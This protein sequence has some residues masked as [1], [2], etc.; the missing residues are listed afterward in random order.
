MADLYIS[1]LSDIDRANIDDALID[2]AENHHNA[3]EVSDNSTAWTLYLHYTDIRNAMILNGVLSDIE[4][5]DVMDCLNASAELCE[6]LRGGEDAEVDAELGSA[7]ESY[8]QTM[9][10]IRARMA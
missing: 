1:E 5:P 4:V 6:E 7:A 3:W 10:E 8:R 9:S 2:M